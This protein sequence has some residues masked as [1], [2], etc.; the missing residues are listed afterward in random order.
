PRTKAE[1]VILSRSSAKAKN[2]VLLVLCPGGCEG[3]LRGAKR[4]SNLAPSSSL[5]SLLRSA[6][7]DHPS[8]SGGR[9]TSTSS[10]TKVYPLGPRLC[11][12]PSGV[13][14]SAALRGVTA[15]RA[16]QAGRPQALPGDE[17]T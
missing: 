12:G 5:L 10:S 7:N 1:G 13:G 16:C 2:L 4:R 8:F 6:R 11:L 14:G 17:G 3:S 15:G 9:S